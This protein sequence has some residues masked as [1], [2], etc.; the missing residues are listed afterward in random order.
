MSNWTP[1]ELEIPLTFLGS[2]EYMA[3]IYADAK[4]ADRFPKQ[5]VIAKKRVRSTT[6]LKVRLAP[7]GGCAVRF[8][9]KR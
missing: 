5:T 9:P 4:D 6:R 8:Q 3:E 7:A 1:R 2:G